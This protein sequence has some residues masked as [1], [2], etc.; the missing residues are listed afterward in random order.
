[1]KTASPGLLGDTTRRSYESKLRLFNQFAAPELRALIGELGLRPGMRAL[2]AG[3]GSGEALAWL[4]ASVAPS[5]V[6][7]G[8][9]LAAAHL[10]AA[11][12][13][14]AGRADLVQADITQAPIR[15]ASLDLIWCVNTINHLRDPLAGARGLA[16]LLRPGG[17]LALGQSHLLPEMAFAWDARLERVVTEA[18]RAYYR[19][20]YS[21]DERDTAGIRALLG[22]LRAAGLGDVRAR[23][24]VIERCSPLGPADEAYLSAALLRGY[25]GEQIWPYLAPDDRDALARLADPESPDFCLRRPDFHYLQTFTLVTGE[26]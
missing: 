15:P 16:A 8:M 22:L 17:R 25:W 5:G 23:T 26:R 9:D 12:A 2:D 11:G 7:L 20:K 18:N 24:V 14:G 6:A 21:L 19:D 4:A 1:M 3:C 10:R 13:L